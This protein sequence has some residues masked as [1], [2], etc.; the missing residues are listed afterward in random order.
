MITIELTDDECAFIQEILKKNFTVSKAM[1]F[2]FNGPGKKI[3]NSVYDKFGLEL[4]WEHN[5]E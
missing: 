3:M 5:N 1:G 2:S 4:V